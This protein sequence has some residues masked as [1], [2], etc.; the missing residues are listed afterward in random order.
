MCKIELQFSSQ[1]RHTH[2]FNNQL[3]AICLHSV[4]IFDIPEHPI[5]EPLKPVKEIKFIQQENSFGITPGAELHSY[6]HRNAPYKNFPYYF[7]VII[8][9]VV[10]YTRV[11]NVQTGQQW[12][13]S[14]T[15]RDYA[16]RWVEDNVFYGFQSTRVQ[17]V[18]LQTL[19]SHTIPLTLI[20]ERETP[21][22]HKS[23]FAW[24]SVRKKIRIYSGHNGQNLL[25]ID[26][27]G[28]PTHDRCAFIV[29]VI[30]NKIIIH[31]QN[32]Q[33][34]KTDKIMIFAWKS[35]SQQLIML[36]QLQIQH[37]LESEVFR[38][39]SMGILMQVSHP[40]VGSK[41][42]VGQYLV[43]WNKK[44]SVWAHGDESHLGIQYS[45]VEG[46]Y[47]CSI[48]DSQASKA[49][50]ANTKTKRVLRCVAY[51]EEEQIQQKPKKNKQSKD[52]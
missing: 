51:V 22:F 39:S 11:T 23:I 8:D 31:Q 3:F 30:H 47:H 5:E 1:L 38:I 40:T 29:H 46:H 25:D 34:D 50:S 37:S 9:S 6:A 42:R 43:G 33:K 48:L 18:D 36:S 44:L 10:R 12:I 19:N 17:V 49:F 41:F 13:V 21:T 4:Q 20:H 45:V 24:I 7:D 16:E 28:K 35:K 14:D 2:L 15:L 27:P 52:I 32:K 26:N